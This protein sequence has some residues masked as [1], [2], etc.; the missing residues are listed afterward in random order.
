MT[1]ASPLVV[2]LASAWVRILQAAATKMDVGVTP[3]TEGGPTVLTGR[4]W[5]TSKMIAEP[6]LYK[7][8][9]KKKKKNVI[10]SVTF[11]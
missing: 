7:K 10:I 9:K 8:K 5:K 1:K 6:R 3:P 2:W 11:G 4:E